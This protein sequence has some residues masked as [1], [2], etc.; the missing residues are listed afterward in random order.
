MGLG[1]DGGGHLPDRVRGYRDVADLNSLAAAMI[2]VGLT[3]DDVSA[4]MGG[5][6]L[7]VFK[8]CTG[9]KPAG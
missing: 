5:N 3:R 9:V 2:D 6:F 7:R 1:T 4:Y 8:A